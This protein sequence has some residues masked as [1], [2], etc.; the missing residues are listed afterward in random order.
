L[1]SPQEIPRP[2]QQNPER[3]FGL[4]EL[5]GELGLRPSQP[6]ELKNLLKH[7]VPQEACLHE[8]AN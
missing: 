1:P 6:P 7:L 4:R 8:K 3:T 2:F 5:V